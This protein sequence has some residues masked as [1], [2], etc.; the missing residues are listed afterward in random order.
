MEVPQAVELVVDTHR[1]TK[2]LPSFREKVSVED[3]SG[4]GSKD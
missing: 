2:P 3:T 4:R 1:P